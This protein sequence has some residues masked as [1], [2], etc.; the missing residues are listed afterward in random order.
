M[1]PRSSAGWAGVLQ[2]NHT[3]VLPW[4]SR[5]FA[6]SMTSRGKHL[7]VA[8][9]SVRIAMYASGPLHRIMGNCSAQVRKLARRLLVW[10]M[11]IPP[12]GDVYHEHRPA[13]CR[14]ET[15]NHLASWLE[16]ARQHANPNM[17]I[18]LIGNKSDLT[19]RLIVTQAC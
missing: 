7:S 12:Y 14:R 5:S 18:M 16:D 13:P 1:D 6:W 15:F 8:C 3:V 11:H 4:R 9:L 17:T 19:V 2:V 10:N